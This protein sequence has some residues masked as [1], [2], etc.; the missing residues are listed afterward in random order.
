MNYENFLIVANGGIMSQ[1]DHLPP[2]GVLETKVF[3]RIGKNNKFIKDRA[4]FLLNT[5]SVKYAAVLER[6]TSI[7]WNR[8]PLG[9]ERMLTDAH[10][11]TDILDMSTLD[12]LA[13]YKVLIIPDRGFNPAGN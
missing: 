1:G 12:Q 10:I 4:P 11:Q 3:E 6:S 8:A 13:N 9:A 2:N 5:K 7:Y